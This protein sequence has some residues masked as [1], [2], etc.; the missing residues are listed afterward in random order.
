MTNTSC[1]SWGKNRGTGL[2]ESI[3][4]LAGHSALTDGD[5][6]DV[7]RLLLDRER[8][9]AETALR[10]LLKAAQARRKTSPAAASEAAA[11]LSS[12][13]E[14]SPGIN[15]FSLGPIVKELSANVSAN[16]DAAASS[17]LSSGQSRLHPPRPV[18]SGNPAAKPNAKERGASQV[19]LDFVSLQL[20]PRLLE[21]SLTPIEDDAIASAG[22]APA[23]AAILDAGG[24][25]LDAFFAE[26]GKSVSLFLPAANEGVF[27]ALIRI[28][29]GPEMKPARAASAVRQIISH[30]DLFLDRRPLG[31]AAAKENRP[32]VSL[33]STG[34]RLVS[35]ACLGLLAVDRVDVPVGDRELPVER[36]VENSSGVSNVDN[37]E[38]EAAADRPS[39]RIR[40]SYAF[41]ALADVFRRPFLLRL[42]C[43]ACFDKSGGSNK[44]EVSVEAVAAGQTKAETEK[45]KT[46]TSTCSRG[47]L[48]HHYSSSLGEVACTEMSA[49]LVAAAAAADTFEEAVMIQEGVDKRCISGLVAEAAG[50]FLEGL[51]G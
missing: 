29:S 4:R 22:P 49:L 48:A 12:V 6:D 1:Q 38:S 39:W 34:M 41:G 14:D 50:L 46:K 42:A 47:R 30:L 36:G 44:S 31:T 9:E 28:L 15:A 35:A 25:I 27:S 13:L 33:F 43:P 40:R 51:C 10:L 3:A 17:K 5:G 11:R 23:P 21:D 20:F 26:T 16:V 18:N 8:K 32:G 37:S 24:E 7:G 2:A 45:S 19:L